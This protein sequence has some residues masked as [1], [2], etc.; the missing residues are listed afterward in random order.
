VGEVEV[1]DQAIFPRRGRL[2][3]A[4]RGVRLSFGEQ[5]HGDKRIGPHTPTE[6]VAP[7]SALA[8]THSMSRP[9]R[10]QTDP[11]DDEAVELAALSVAVENA[12]VNK[13]G[14]PHEEMR[15]WLLEIAAGDFDAPP[16]VARDL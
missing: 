2:F 11:D 4:D 16:P 10:L 7:P 3:E 9:I 5:P 6:G 13:R 15:V 8:Y 12:R 1:G 14:I